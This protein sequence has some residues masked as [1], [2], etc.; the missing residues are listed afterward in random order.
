MRK[1]LL[2]VSVLFCTGDG[3]GITSAKPARAGEMLVA[4]F[5][6]PERDRTDA[7]SGASRLIV[8]GKATGNV[9]FV[10]SAIQRAVGGDLCM[11]FTVDAKLYIAG[12]NRA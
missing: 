2:F 4:Y 6:V 5:S 12:A 10:A 11:F 3:Y 9:Q 8:D 7:V 1:L